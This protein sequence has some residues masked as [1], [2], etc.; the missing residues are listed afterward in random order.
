MT[1]VRV[2]LD[3]RP[4][5]VNREGIGRYTRELV[6]AL[7]ELGADDNLALFGSTLS[8]ARFSAEELGLSN[9][10]ARSLRLRVPS[11]WLPFLMGASG[12]GAD[13]W[14]GGV[15]V[16]H[17]TQPNLLTVRE[18]A[19]V[20]TIFDCIFINPEG[21]LDRGGWLDVAGARRMEQAAR[22][23]VERSRL[24][25]VPTVYVAGEVARL[26]GAA[27]EK[28][29]VTELG[30][31][32]A[33]R[34]ALPRTRPASASEAFVLTVSRVDG[35]KNHV[36]MLA[37]FEKLVAAGLPQRWIVAG[38]RGHGADAFDAAL[39]RSSAR[40]RIVRLEHVSEAEL[41]RLYAAADAFLFASLSEGF[42][43]PPLEA[44]LHAVPTVVAKATCLPEVC[45]DGALYVDPLDVDSIAA[46]L[47]R[48]LEDKDLA[49]ELSERGLARAKKFT[50]SAC[51]QKTL[52]AYAAAGC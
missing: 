2:G 9:S 4:A 17:H 3:Y 14:L 37:A 45:G 15:D 44:M 26:L 24:L 16:F 25:L 47:A 51:A 41:A 42:G 8:P 46:G 48:V 50:W 29:V 12:R 30:C 35:R 34:R 43:L 52:A 10:K 33:T 19:Q 38:P 1:R 40:G 7:V 11:K 18:A 49:G 31:D 13:D 21:G 27:P 5:L 36:R 6:R 23:Q 28:I 32:H 39:E 22:A 20:A